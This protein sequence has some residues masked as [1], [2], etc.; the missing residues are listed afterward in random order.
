MAPL[1]A[2]LVSYSFPPVGGAGVQRM[3]KLAKYLPEHGVQPAVLTVANPSVPV[4]DHSLERDVAPEM[5]V[6]RARTFEPGYALKKATWKAHAAGDG[7]AAVSLR[8]RIVGGLK[9]RAGT[10]A[11]QVLVPDPQILW[12]PAAQLAVARRLAAGADDVVLVS[13]PPFSQ[14]LLAPIVRA[15]RRA[16]VVLDYRDEWSTYRTAYEMTGRLAAAVGG[17]LEET[18]LRA[19]HAVTTATPEFRENLLA[20]HRFLD[21][22]R[23]VVIPN[24]YDRDDF[25]AA[26]PEPPADRFV[27]TYAGTIFKLT[28]ARG[29]L[30]AVRRLHAAEPA[31]ARKLELRFYG[32]VV[33]TEQDAFA[34]MDALGVRQLG[35]VDHAALF[36]VLAASHMTLCLLD[37]VPGNERI[38]PAKVF[39]LMHLGRPVLTLAPEGALANLCRE[40]R[41]GDV[42]PPRDEAAIAALLERRI[43]DF[44]AGRYVARARAIGV[45][46]YDRRLLAREFAAVLHDAAGRPMPCVM[47]EVEERVAAAALGPDEPA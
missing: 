1:R 45:E 35:Y 20:R 16:A 33:D 27:L 10:L 12:Q 36:E 25:P 9:K 17:P 3:V 22:R 30:G 28:S 47:P 44:E 6:V 11:R 13:A 8:S 38:Y 23:V 5:E 43:R 41:L 31:L 42:L 40:H 34:G 46:R 19:A 18:L 15:S 24:G 7:G 37:D 4:I 26:R 32:R 39:E 21:E 2:L 29:L 14:F